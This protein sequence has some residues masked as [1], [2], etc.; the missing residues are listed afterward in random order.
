MASEK[1]LLRTILVVLLIVAGSQV[2]FFVSLHN[3]KMPGIS[4]SSAVNSV[5]SNAAPVASSTPNIV[6]GDDPIPY[7]GN[8]TA[9]QNGRMQIKTPD[10]TVTFTLSSN[11][12]FSTPGTQKSNMQINQELA[13]YNAKV[14]QL[15]QD[16]AKNAAALKSMTVPSTYNQT[17]LTLSDFKVGDYVYVTPGAK[18]G[19]GSYAATAVSLANAA[20]TTMQ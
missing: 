14:T 2:Y 5:P 19:D 3:M 20:T 11:T 13:A 16:P 12:N 18:N 8:I 17:T 7:Q 9:I 4:G 6:V 1:L 10:G 15:M